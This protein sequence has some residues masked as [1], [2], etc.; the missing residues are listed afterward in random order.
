MFNYTIRSWARGHHHDHAH[1][2]Q[3]GEMLDRGGGGGG[4]TDPMDKLSKTTKTPNRHKKDSPDVHVAKKKDTRKV[5][6]VTIEK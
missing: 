1:G 2:A 5:F 4:G 3:S 6:I